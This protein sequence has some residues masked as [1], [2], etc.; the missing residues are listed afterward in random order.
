MA[1]KYC[2]KRN[3]RSQKIFNRFWIGVKS[4]DLLGVATAIQG[5]L[6]TYSMSA[7]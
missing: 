7:N 5:T 1:K 4:Y 3:D 6:I 2:N